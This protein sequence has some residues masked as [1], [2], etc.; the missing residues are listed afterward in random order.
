MISDW[1]ND[2][3]RKM[4]DHT[5]EVPDGLW[6]DIRDELFGEDNTKKVVGITDL[7]AS[8]KAFSKINYKTIFYWA[9]G[10]AA[11]MAL[12]FVVD[13]LIDFSGEKDPLHAS[14][15]SS[16]TNKI[17]N[18]YK[19]TLPGSAQ[20]LSNRKQKQI[21]ENLIKEKRDLNKN[22][23]ENIFGAKKKK[24]SDFWNIFLEENKENKTKEILDNNIMI[25]AQKQN[26]G[27][28]EGD[29]EGG[30]YERLTKED[31]ERKEKLE[32]EK[33]KLS[34]KIKKTWMLGVLSGNTSSNTI[35]QFL[36]YATLNGTALSL[37]DV[38]STEYGEDPL[39]A[40]LIANQDK[41][42]DAKIKHE[43]PITFGV[44]VYRGLGK[45]WGIT[46]G[47]NYTKLSAEL[48]T[49]SESNFISSVQNIHYVG[50]PVQVNYNVIEKEAFTGYVSVGGAVEKLVSGNIRT[51]YIVDEVIKEDTKEK[52]DEKP[53]QVSLNTSVGVQL[54]IAKSF[55]LYAEPGVSYHF[56]DNST[57]NTIYKEK[58]L[59][60]NVKFG[61]RV[62]LD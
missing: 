9:G 4:E 48:T 61:V 22:I 13:T 21:A 43:T 51:K 17:Y 26:K 57:L 23:I 58:P 46:T 44:S 47:V 31:K 18:G 2:L 20:E 27:A 16:N 5:E 60:F 25:L 49:G 42:V 1:F 33:I 56:K 7:K 52:I 53:V 14:N 54:K 37:P 8:Q 11:A 50:I 36:G 3:R 15:Y 40:I 19:K 34:N 30:K 45:K 32:E 6:D 55:G 24:T 41:K 12:F 29:I 35:D 28:I 59:N 38:W 10:I 39:M 62:L